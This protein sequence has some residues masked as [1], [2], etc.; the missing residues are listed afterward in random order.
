MEAS[1]LLATVYWI[2]LSGEHF[3][4]LLPV[5]PSLW[6][7]SCSKCKWWS[8]SE[9]V[10]SVTLDPILLSPRWIRITMFLLSPL[11]LNCRC[12]HIAGG[13]LPIHLTE[14]LF[15]LTRSYM[16][17]PW[18]IT[19]WHKK[20]FYWWGHDHNLFPSCQ[21]KTHVLK[22]KWYWFVIF[23]FSYSSRSKEIKLYPVCK[24]SC[25]SCYTAWT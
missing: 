20:I 5:C 3:H 9:T 18:G 21:P 2:L 4:F 11:Y 24:F 16:M 15:F 17:M 12:A 22:H 1:F 19:W 14:F 25:F 13:L 23:C 7:Q 6:E 10:T 8:L